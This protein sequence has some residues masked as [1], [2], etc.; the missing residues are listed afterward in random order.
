M[1]TDTDF[2]VLRQIKGIGEKRYAQIISTA[3]MQEI[4][5]AQM[6]HMSADDLKAIFHLPINVARALEVFFTQ[7][8][9][10][11]KA[12]NPL[13]DTVSVFTAIRKIQISDANYPKRLKIVLGAKAPQQIYVWGN[14]SLVDRPSVGFCGS[15]KVSDKGLSVTQDA[16]SQ[17]A[18][19]AWVIVSGHA[20]G[21]DVTAHSN[22][23]KVGASTIIVAAEGLESFKLRAELKPYVTPQ[24][25]LIISI[26]E[27]KD[28]W[29]VW[30]AMRRNEIIIALSDAMILVEAGLQGGTFEAG[31]QTLH[32]KQPLYVVEYGQQSEH[33]SGNTYFIERGADTLRKNKQNNRANIQPIVEQIRHKTHEENNMTQLS[34]LV[35]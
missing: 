31:K 3:Q 20:K 11:S 24:N 28:G 27:P 34:F 15:R 8:P 25:T 10:H 19:M 9:R 35:E 7:Q 26:F 17:F 29:T 13:I 33:N 5:L 22:A 12:I 30:R 23:L 21:V 18:E 14:L 2:E 1:T 4:T 16:A 32:L 6:M